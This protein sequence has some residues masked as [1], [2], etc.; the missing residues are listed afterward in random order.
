MSRFLRTFLFMVYVG[1][2]MLVIP[3]AM[4]RG[5]GIVLDPLYHQ[6]GILEVGVLVGAYVFALGRSMLWPQVQRA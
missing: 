5:G 6:I 2:G 1:N 3:N 4:D